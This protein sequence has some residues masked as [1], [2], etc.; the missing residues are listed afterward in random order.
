MT[1][2][3]FQAE[4]ILEALQMVQ[5]EMGP[6]A[7]VISAR[8]IPAGPAWQVWKKPGVE[9]ISVS[10]DE[11][12]RVQGLHKKFDQPTRIIRPNRNGTGVEFIEENPSI[13]WEEGPTE[14]ST[15]NPLESTADQEKPSDHLRLEEF[16]NLWKPRYLH[17]E[18]VRAM[19]QLLAGRK[20][21]QTGGAEKGATIIQ[22]DRLG[23]TRKKTHVGD[24]ALPKP[25]RRILDK[26]AFQG[27][28]REYMDQMEELII[29]G[30]NP[31]MRE[32]ERRVR[33]FLSNHLSANITIRRF[34]ATEVP[35][36]VMIFTGLSGCGKT[37]SLAKIAVFYSSLL[38]KK[39]VWICAD[40][41][42]TGA[43]AE[44]KA[45]TEA[46]GIP[47]ELVYTPSDLRTA[48]DRHQEA[49]LILVDTPGF[50]PKSE[51]QQV[52]L[53]SLLTEVPEAQIFLVASATAKESDSLHCFD[54]LKYFG[55]KGCVLTKLDETS[56]YGSVYNLARKSRLP[57][58]FF[59]SSR[60]ASSGLKVAE[61]DKLVD[62]LFIGGW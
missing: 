60:K 27:V 9:V 18:D 33:E 51:E 59:S 61:A 1:T 6:D 52:E 53:G 10:P 32:N 16:K 34:S 11:I 28:D 49:D 54:T 37:S 8:D 36:R 45:Y 57:L 58:A 50:N 21:V 48:I 15:G 5:K 22:P 13:E 12:H 56:T 20:Q 14:K 62:A 24:A 43:I 26:L 40:T 39:V 35:A 46:A 41:V 3:T 38:T 2:K 23:E 42:R 17:R 29:N 19:N 7:V 44:A 55:L 4:T 30:C 25:T 31:A 47:M